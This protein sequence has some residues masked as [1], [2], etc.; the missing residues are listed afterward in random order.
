[1]GTE[2]IDVVLE[3]TVVASVVFLLTLLS[4]SLARDVWKAFKKKK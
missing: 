4:V 1:M 3:V 2:L